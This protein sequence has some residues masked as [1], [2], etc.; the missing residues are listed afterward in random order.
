MVAN[1]VADSMQFYERIAAIYL[2]GA[3]RGIDKH[4][5]NF[6]TALQNGIEELAVNGDALVA[7]RPGDVR[8][9]KPQARHS[10]KPLPVRRAEIVRRR[11]PIPKNARMEC[12]R[13]AVMRNAPIDR[14]R[15]LVYRT[16][17]GTNHLKAIDPLLDRHVDELAGIRTHRVNPVKRI[18]SRRAAR[19]FDYAI[20]R[21]G[22]R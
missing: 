9:R 18:D 10:Q 13:L 21:L 16:A 2:R 19:P 20:H 5:G 4:L 22:R 7:P 3:G 6:V 11:P 12:D 1:I 15:L 14:Q 8:E 17:F